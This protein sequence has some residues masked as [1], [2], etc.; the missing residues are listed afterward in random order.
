MAKAVEESKRFTDM[1]D[2]LKKMIQSKKEDFTKEERD[3]LS[4]GF[5]NQ[6]RSKM[7]AIRT[8]SAFEHNP[9]YQNFNVSL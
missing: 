7:T 6:I 5:M 9:K 1:F 8:I 3:L 4:S 2:Y